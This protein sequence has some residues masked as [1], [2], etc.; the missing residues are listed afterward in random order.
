MTLLQAFFDAATEPIFIVDT[1]SRLVVDANPR[2]VAAS[3]YDL[4][5]LRR[6]P[7]MRLFGDGA[8]RLFTAESAEVRAELRTRT[9]IARPIAARLTRVPHAGRAYLFVI[10]LDDANAVAT[11][12]D[13]TVAPAADDQ[14]IIGRSTRIETVR[15]LIGSVA[16]SNATVLIQGASG[17]G[18]EVV[19]NAIHARSRRHRGPFVKVNCAALTESL[20]ESELFGH[21]KGAFTGAVGDRRGRF[22]QADRGTILLDEIGSMPLAG[23]AALLRV[24]QEREF[25]PVGSSVTTPVD[26]RVIAATNT[27]LARAVDDGQFRADL[28]YRLNVFGITLPALRD[29]PDDI[30]VL[31]EYFLQRYAA[32]TGKTIRGFA[33]DALAALVEH[34][35]PGNVRQ[36][37][38]AIEHAVIVEAHPLVQAASLPASLAPPALAVAELRGREP[39]L[40][41]RMTVIERQ[42]LL[43][44]LTRANGIKKRAAEMLGIDSRNMPYFLRKHG[45]QDAAR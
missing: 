42:I 26:V 45:L 10:V 13:A 31:A 39:G 18:K 15:R 35:W 29:R 43:E 34:D 38:N 21:V 1:C 17:T 32:A 14:D 40:R 23:Q 30:P 19:A 9:G 12:A 3:G 36:L 8:S 20:L 44:T 6:L 7:V 4:D 28:Y 25:E 33:V 2:G 27:D 5:E 41:E 11:T 16:E 24:L 22:K 37:E